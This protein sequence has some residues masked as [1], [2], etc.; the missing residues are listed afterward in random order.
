MPL[1]SSPRGY[2]SN[3]LTPRLSIM[4]QYLAL[5]FVGFVFVMLAAAYLPGIVHSA[6]SRV[7]LALDPSCINLI[8]AEPEGSKRDIAT[9]CKSVK[10]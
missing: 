6:V 7:N 2:P 10:K 5:A 8:H 1:G 9:I 4:K 3:P